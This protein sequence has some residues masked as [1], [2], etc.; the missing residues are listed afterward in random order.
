MNQ[1]NNTIEN[2][3]KRISGGMGRTQGMRRIQ[4]ARVGKRGS[5]E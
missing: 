2:S 1:S 5:L 3:Q 4:I